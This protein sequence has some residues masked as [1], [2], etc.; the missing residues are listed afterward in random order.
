MEVPPFPTFARGEEEEFLEVTPAL[1]GAKRANSSS[2]NPP[3][4]TRGEEG[5]FLLM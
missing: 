2:G 1:P 5:E 4:F 3:T